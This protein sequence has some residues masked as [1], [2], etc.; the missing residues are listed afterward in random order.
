MSET[1]K[2]VENIVDVPALIKAISAGQVQIDAESARTL[3]AALAEHCIT[4]DSTKR[5]ILSIAT[6]VRGATSKVTPDTVEQKSDVWKRFRNPHLREEFGKLSTEEK[7]QIDELVLHFVRDVSML[8]IQATKPLGAPSAPDGIDHCSFRIRTDAK[9]DERRLSEALCKS[10]NPEITAAITTDDFSISS[11]VILDHPSDPQQAI[12]LCTLSNPLKTSM[13]S[14][15]RGSKHQFS[16]VIAKNSEVL[17]FLRSQKNARLFPFVY[18]N[19]AVQMNAKALLYVDAPLGGG[20]YACR[21]KLGEGHNPL[22]IL[23]VPNRT[24][25]AFRS[26]K[27]ATTVPDTRKAGTDEEFKELSNTYEVGQKKVSEWTHPTLCARWNE[28]D[29]PLEENR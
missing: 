5:Q 8:I 22:V 14:D 24:V 4:D 12:V 26:T 11:I 29:L 20:Q 10:L 6:Q 17:S 9:V 15:Y 21:T 13:Y 1:K 3:I 25:I 2:Q 28:R 16:C 19:A 27:D 23:D 18:R 7:R